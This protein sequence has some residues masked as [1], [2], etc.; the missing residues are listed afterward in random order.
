MHISWDIL[1]V[2]YETSGMCSQQ[3]R[4][5]AGVLAPNRHQ[6]I[7]NHNDEY[8]TIVSQVSCQA[9]YTIML[10]KRNKLCS[11]EVLGSPTHWFHCYWWGPPLRIIIWGLWCQ[12]QVSQ[13]LISNYIPSLLWDAITYPCLRNLLLTPKSSLINNYILQFT[14]GGDYLSLP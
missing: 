11:R 1:T 5:I 3:I 13:V 2:R 8:V 6:V 14:A 9:T 7:S 4:M 12:K 10:W